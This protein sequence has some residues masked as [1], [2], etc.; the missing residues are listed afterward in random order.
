[1]EAPYN[2]TEYNAGGTVSSHSP[3]EV[4]LGVGAGR[5]TS[6]RP[7]RAW[8]QADGCSISKTVM[9]TEPHARPSLA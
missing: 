1:M 8:I 4:L 2:Q 3:G 9:K 7:A 6:H 5:R